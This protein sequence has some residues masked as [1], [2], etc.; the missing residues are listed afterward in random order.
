MA[1]DEEWDQGL[2]ASRA[3]RN[4]LMDDWAAKEKDK[5]A[6]AKK[7][8]R[9]VAHECTYCGKT[10]TAN[11]RACSLC[12]YV[13]F[14]CRYIPHSSLSRSA[15]YCNERC[16][17]AD[18]KARHRAECA[19]FAYPPLTREFL[20]EPVD[21][22]KYAEKPIF[23]QGHKEGVGCWVS[24]DGQVDGKSVCSGIPVVVSLVHLVVATAS[25]R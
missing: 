21:G 6:Q 15:R 3:L 13:A 23:A 12:K 5:H 17:Q 14:H 16:Q 2:L 1:T 4:G 22:A 8:K 7:Y 19:N 25:R 11:L 18:Y 24:C 20:T 9:R 10:D